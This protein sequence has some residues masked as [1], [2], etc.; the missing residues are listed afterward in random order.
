MPI[1]SAS[2]RAVIQ[3]QA[4]HECSFLIYFSWKVVMSGPGEDGPGRPVALP[5]CRD[6]RHRKGGYPRFYFLCWALSLCLSKPF[7]KP[8]GWARVVAEADCLSL[9]VAQEL[10]MVYIA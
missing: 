1:Y 7:Q 4:W 10:R 9:A 5:Q 2:M 3:M 6:E 8:R